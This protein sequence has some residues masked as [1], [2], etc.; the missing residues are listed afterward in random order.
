MQRRLQPHTP[1]WLR[2]SLQS[3]CACV[4]WWRYGALVCDKWT[5]AVLVACSRCLGV[6]DLPKVRRAGVAAL[7]SSLTPIFS[8]DVAN[9]R[10]YHAWVGRLPLNVA[11]SPRLAARQRR[12]WRSRAALRQLDARWAPLL[13][14]GTRGL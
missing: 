7:Y 2:L 5:R 3:A 1:P 11:G 8:L 4:L 9:Y 14:I 10:Y 6:A 13:D 12:R